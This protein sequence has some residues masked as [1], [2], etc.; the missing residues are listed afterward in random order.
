[1]AGPPPLPVFGHEMGLY[2]LVW[3]AKARVRASKLPPAE[4]GEVRGEARN[5]RGM[6]RPVGGP[7]AGLAGRG[8]PKPEPPAA[9]SDSTW[10]RQLRHM[11]VLTT[12]SVRR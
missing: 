6:R 2:R 12:S 5:R 10:A 3:W 1:M 8:Q 7:D 11:H 9:G 4:T